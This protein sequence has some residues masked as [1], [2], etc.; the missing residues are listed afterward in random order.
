MCEFCKNIA[1]NDNQFVNKRIQG[2]DFIFRDDNGYGILAD[3]G[4]SFC[5][6]VIGNILYCPMCGRDLRR[7]GEN[8]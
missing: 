5:L 8:E 7:N 1:E 3:T 6:G 2:G 4:D